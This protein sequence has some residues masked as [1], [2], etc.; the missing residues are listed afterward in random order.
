MSQEQELR[1][2]SGADAA[3][4]TNA[5]SEAFHSADGELVDL[6][7]YGTLLSDRHVQLLIGRKVETEQA[8]LYHFMRV[9]PPGAFYF[10]V[11]QHG[12]VTQG[13]LLKNISRQELAK[14]DAFEDEGTLYFRK[15]VIVRTANGTRQRC[16]TYVGNIPALQKSYGKDILFEDRYSLYL[17]KKID[18]ILE[19]I[20]PAR[21]EIMRRAL[22]EL[23]GAEVDS[24]I[25]SHFDGNYICNYIMVQSLSDAKPPLLVNVVANPAVR[26]YADNY[27]KFACKHIVFNQLADMIRRR[28]PDSV[29]LARKYYRHGLSI[30]LAFMYYNRKKE[31]IESLLTAYSLDHLI[32][33]RLYRDYAVQCIKLA[34]QI[35]S[36]ED[37]LELID[38]V[39]S[40][41]YSAPTPIGAE[42]EF[43]HLGVHAIDA[44]P[45][46]DPVF[47]GFYWFDDFDLQRRTWRVGGHVD[48]HRNITPGM[49]RH[50]GFFEYALGR[51]NIVGDLS[52]PLFDCPWGMSRL[53]NEA[54]RF[55][56]EIPPH[57]LHVS[58]E[59]PERAKSTTMQRHKESDL[60]CLLLLGGDFRKDE[61]GNLREWRIYN[62]ELDTNRMRSLNFSD[63]KEHYSRPEQE[64]A[65]DV[66]E[67]KY[68]R[69]HPEE[70][71]YHS[72]IVALKGYQAGSHGRPITIQ[73]QGA[74]ELPEQMFLRE[75][76]ANPTPLD[77]KEIDAF[78]AT[79]EAGLKVEHNSL[80]LDRRRRAVMEKLNLLL[81]LKNY[82]IK[83]ALEE[84]R[85]G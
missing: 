2:N 42:L 71:D 51:F 34:E 1:R 85:N 56:R 69:L 46:D 41:W 67:Y 80:Q 10:I 18:T 45:G 77:D 19:K 30:L 60:A 65:S 5:V 31:T 82:E 9:V 39:D 29:R 22:R 33:G 76:A 57:S 14:I 37:M 36:D 62:N 11:K 54:V 4:L 66:I 16:L 78:L 17:D 12:A 26:P 38:Y 63:R 15:Q 68:L 6:F 32:P 35:Y 59:L 44:Q 74:G 83:N 47:D 27:I 50:R 81:R 25:E 73:R 20:E 61:N 48:S 3:Q 70:T 49:K 84:K 21:H 58:M 79:V 53:I 8:K 24:L 7:V 13:R 40:H 55:L 75:W 23:L 52:R 64:D 43:S 28:Y 72:I